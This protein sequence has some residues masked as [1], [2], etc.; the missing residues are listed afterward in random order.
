MDST[1][2]SPTFTY[3]TDGRYRATLT[4]TDVGGKDRGRMAS[5][6]VDIAVGGQAPVVTFVDPDGEHPV[7]LR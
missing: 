5:A 1:E 4:V 3:E 7:L 6:Y 2:V